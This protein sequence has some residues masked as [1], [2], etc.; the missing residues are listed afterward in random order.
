MASSV[1]NGGVDTQAFVPL[2]WPLQI[3]D[4][5]LQKPTTS[6]PPLAYQIL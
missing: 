4:V 6:Q 2:P 5:Q 1:A 3:Y